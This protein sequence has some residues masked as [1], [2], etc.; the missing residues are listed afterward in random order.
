ME[1]AEQ[2]QLELPI[3][4]KLAKDAV[5]QLSAHATFENGVPFASYAAAKEA[6][7]RSGIPAY[8]LLGMFQAESDKIPPRVDIRA[9]DSDAQTWSEFFSEIAQ[10]VIVGKM[11]VGY[12]DVVKDAYRR[13]QDWEESHPN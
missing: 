9:I 4:D 7:R 6:V 8:N 1:R 12:P 10:E 2:E 11:N 13:L 5:D 3:A